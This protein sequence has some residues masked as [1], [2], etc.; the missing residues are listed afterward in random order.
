MFL[1]DNNHQKNNVVVEQTLIKDTVVLAPPLPANS[2]LINNE[3][4][5]TTKVFQCKG[6]PFCKCTI[7]FSD[8]D[9]G[10][11]NLKPFSRSELTDDAESWN[12]I[13]ELKMTNEDHMSNMQSMNDAISSLVTDFPFAKRPVERCTIGRD[14]QLCS[15]LNTNCLGIRQSSLFNPI[16]NNNWREDRGP[17]PELDRHPKNFLNKDIQYLYR[18]QKN[19][20][21]NLNKS[22]SQFYINKVNDVKKFQAGSEETPVRQP[23]FPKAA[24]LGFEIFDY[25][26]NKGVKFI[27]Q[28]DGEDHWIEEMPNPVKA[29]FRY[30][31]VLAKYLRSNTIDIDAYRGLI[32]NNDFKSLFINKTYCN[33]SSGINSL[34][35]T[36]FYHSCEALVNYSTSEREIYQSVRCAIVYDHETLLPTLTRVDGLGAQVDY[37]AWKVL[38][39]VGDVKTNIRGKLRGQGRQYAV[40]D[41]ESK[42]Y[43]RDNLVKYIALFILFILIIVL[44]FYIYK[45]YYDQESSDKIKE[46]KGKTKVG[47]GHTRQVYSQHT[48]GGKVRKHA[49]SVYNAFEDFKEQLLNDDKLVCEDGEYYLDGQ[50]IDYKTLMGRFMLTQDFEIANRNARIYEEEWSDE[51]FYND[52]DDA[53]DE[54]YAYKKFLDREYQ[55][56]LD[57]QYEDFADYGID[58]AA[59]I[60]HNGQIHGQKK[61]GFLE[62]KFLENPSSVSAMFNKICPLAEVRRNV[63]DL[64]KTDASEEDFKALVPSWC[65]KLKELDSAKSNILRAIA[66]KKKSES[67]ISLKSDN[68]NAPTLIKQLIPFQ[69]SYLHSYLTKQ[70]G[71]WNKN[72][73]KSQDD[74]IAFYLM[75]AEYPEMFAE[76]VTKDKKLQLNIKETIEFSVSRVMACFSCKDKRLFISSVAQHIFGSKLEHQMKFDKDRYLTHY[77]W[78]R[79]IVN[80]ESNF[81][82]DLIIR[83]SESIMSNSLQP[84]EKLKLKVGQ[85]YKN[86]KFFSSATRCNG[87]FLANVHAFYGTDGAYSD[88]IYTILISGSVYKIEEH[89]LRKVGGDLLFISVSGLPKV[90]SATIVEH[91]DGEPVLLY[92]ANEN[93]PTV[94]LVAIAGQVYSTNSQS[95]DDDELLTN[96]STKEGNCGGFYM[97]ASGMVGIHTA[98]SRNVNFM[99]NLK[100]HEENLLKILP[101]RNFC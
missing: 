67:N 35:G 94:E 7:S 25:T 62:S 22:M 87:G 42:Y 13:N 40:F 70:L 1:N 93:G 30:D 38:S 33:E 83:Q 65:S 64:C 68:I 12:P 80:N 71:D 59:P 19:H 79:I 31:A 77:S 96:A 8:D 3:V 92:T 41:T 21:K 97:S 78:K 46:T 56:A 48:K 6:N 90:S 86:G 85:I 53:G 91:K 28:H 39:T 24:Q 26:K 61:N 82:N 100:F 66:P 75:I 51:E 52:Y 9:E 74:K 50:P 20:I 37:M 98:G 36:K 73:V 18:Q 54:D 95:G 15:G 32:R 99:I 44:F 29:I 14:I 5:D 17:R 60:Y 23:S 63:K 27:N 49:H 88:A 47:R 58:G 4:Q 69:V 43:W 84:N 55:D 2:V 16:D 10:N 81:I 11:H 45:R 34:D 57:N 101:N 72:F 89:Q 76:L